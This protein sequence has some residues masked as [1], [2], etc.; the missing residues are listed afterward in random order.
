M[1]FR[2]RL[3]LGVQSLLQPIVVSSSQTETGPTSDI[4]YIT[5]NT[6]YTSALRY[7][8]LAPLESTS[9]RGSSNRE[10]TGI[11]SAIAKLTPVAYLSFDGGRNDGGYDTLISHLVETLAISIDIVLNKKIGV[12]DGDRVRPMTLQI[13]DILAD[14]QKQLTQENLGSYVHRT[15]DD[16]L[17]HEVYLE[18]WG[19]DERFHGGEIEV[20]QIRYELV[21]ASPHGGG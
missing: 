12:R 10:P 2:E 18:E 16:V 13:S 1:N 4:L 3:I 17:L 8:Y 5:P 20:L 11:G 15:E 6:N 7:L 14:I 19:F 21:V 9:S